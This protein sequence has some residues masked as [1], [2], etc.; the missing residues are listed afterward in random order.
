MKNLVKDQLTRLRLSSK[1]WVWI[2]YF[3]IGISVVNWFQPNCL[4]LAGDFSWPISFS[5]FI[6]YTSYIWDDSINCGYLAAR[7]LASFYPYAFWGYVMEALGLSS[8]S[9]QIVMFYVSFAMSG[10]GMYLLGGK[11]RMGHI[12]ATAAGI[13]YMLSPYALAVAWVPAYGTTFPFYCFLP[14]NLFFFHN[15]IEAESSYG[16]KALNMLGI[17]FSWLGMSYSNPAFFVLFICL[18]FFFFLY[19]YYLSV[20]RLRVTLNF[21]AFVNIYLA[22]NA[23]WL[24]P[25]ICSISQQFAG[26]SNAAAGLISDA[27]TMKLNSVNMIEGLRMTGLWS[28]RAEHWGD[29]YYDWHNILSSSIYIICSFLVTALAVFVLLTVETRKKPFVLF[30]AGL[31]CIG[32]MLNTGFR[33]GG[34]F[35]YINDRIFFDD[36]LRR[37]FRSIYLKLG[38]LL[39]LPTALL[40]G[41]CISYWEQRVNRRVLIVSGLLTLLALFVVAKP[42]FS[43]EIIK[44]QGKKLPSYNVNIPQEYYDLNMQESYLKLDARYISLPLPKSYNHVLKWANSGYNGADFLRFF[45][46]RPAIYMNDGSRM[47]NLITQSLNEEK[48]NILTLLSFSNVRYVFSH[49]DIPDYAAN[50][51]LTGNGGDNLGTNNVVANRYFTVDSITNE[52]FLPHVYMANQIIHNISDND[53]VY[54]TIGE[55]IREKRIAIY[56]DSTSTSYDFD[57]S[58]PVIEY[59]K[60]SPVKYRI[61]VHRAKPNSVVPLVF[62]ERFDEEWKIYMTPW[63]RGGISTAKLHKYRLLKGNERDQADRA[64]VSDFINEGFV[65]VIGDLGVKKSIYKRWQNGELLGANVEEYRIDFISKKF[66]GTIQNDNLPNGAF[67][68]TWFSQPAVIEKNHLM[69]NGYANSWI[70]DIDDI[71]GKYPSE[72]PR[73]CKK[74]GDGTYD[75]ELVIEYR[76]QKLFYFGMA[77]SAAVLLVIILYLFCFLGGKLKAA[78]FHRFTNVSPFS[79]RL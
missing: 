38:I 23:Y 55:N 41:I 57:S 21:L 56:N 31:L 20:R 27:E 29:Y 9:I 24:I 7:Q 73:S 28:L 70:L 37:A 19:E 13:I 30:M 75:F 47:I 26:A 72:D 49:N 52:C 33:T 62:S 22:L 46:Y 74:S 58:T 11:L 32:L 76:L 61:R 48:G 71:C 53:E 50:G 45:L 59:A 35:E 54:D 18:L 69:V 6:K 78:T 68:E 16:E 60:I 77:I 36:F 67:Y 2:I 25:F 8:R 34:V 39:V 1:W 10:V 44:G 40:A 15:F 66:Q 51:Y 43:G 63:Q 79:G 65:S 4:I 17:A 14:L 64:E 42:F 5:K 12:G 3:I